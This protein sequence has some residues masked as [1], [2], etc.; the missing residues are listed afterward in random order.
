MLGVKK[1]TL[2]NVVFLCKPGV[3]YSNYK[4]GVRV[5]ITADLDLFYKH[6]TIQLQYKRL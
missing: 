3:K 2:R 4:T 6:I 5:Q 1:S